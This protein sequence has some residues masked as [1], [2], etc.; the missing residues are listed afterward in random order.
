MPGHVGAQR[1]LVRVGAGL[2]GRP[3]GHR[4]PAPAAAGYS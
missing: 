2:A 1:G 3:A 4:G